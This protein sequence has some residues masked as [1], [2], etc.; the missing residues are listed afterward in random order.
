M[1]N[2]EY[3]TEMNEINFSETDNVFM[4]T[5]SNFQK[6]IHRKQVKFFRKIKHFFFFEKLAEFIVQ[7]EQK[8]I[9][10]LQKKE[11]IKKKLETK[12]VEFQKKTVKSFFV[13]RVSQKILKVGKNQKTQTSDVGEKTKN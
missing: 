4:N 2:G 1:K 7:K 3:E 12:S 10:H 11:E 8:F 5:V 6:E 13:Y 9:D